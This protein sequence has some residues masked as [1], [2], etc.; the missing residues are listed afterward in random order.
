MVAD[1]RWKFRRFGFNELGQNYFVKAAVWI[2]KLP[3]RR[4]EDTW[5]QAADIMLG[6][7]N[8]L[9]CSFIPVIVDLAVM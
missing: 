5:Y 1:E 6:I 3:V 7:P 2:G 4:L 8:H 9:A